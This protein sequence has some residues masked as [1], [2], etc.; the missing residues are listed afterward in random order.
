MK[1]LHRTCPKWKKN[2]KKKKKKKEE[3]G[4]KNLKFL[5]SSI[6]GFSSRTFFAL[7]DGNYKTQRL[8]AVYLQLVLMD[9]KLNL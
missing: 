7:S 3:T 1:S 9:F 2:P 8:R 4:K 5:I 6:Y